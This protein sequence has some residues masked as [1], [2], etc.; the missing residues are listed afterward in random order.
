MP[1]RPGLQARLAPSKPRA[2]SASSPSCAKGA[3]TPHGHGPHGQKWAQDTPWW[4]RAHPPR[5][6]Q[7][8]PAPCPRPWGDAVPN[9]NMLPSHPRGPGE[10]PGV[11][12]PASLLNAG[13]PRPA[14]TQF[15]LRVRGPGPDANA[16]TLECKAAPSSVNRPPRRGRRGSGAG[17]EGPLGTE[18]VPAPAQHWNATLQ[19]QGTPRPQSLTPHSA[20]PAGVQTARVAPPACPPSTPAP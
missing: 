7:P 19:A 5:G 13:T 18:H 15:L 17:T 3:P 14:T 10:R 2:P 11:S 12:A 8:G 4:G 1:Q 6:P 16:E 9:A 20:R